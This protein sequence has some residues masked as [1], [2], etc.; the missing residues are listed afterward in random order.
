MPH[1]DRTTVEK[2]ASLAHI[3]LNED[4]LAYYQTQ[5]DKILDHMAALGSYIDGL[6]DDWRPELELTPTLERDDVAKPSQVIERVLG[7]AP[8]VVG[9]AFQVPR[10]IE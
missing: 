4:E 5:F 7:T 1:I 3:R 6:P 10:I 2:I 9:T 8:R